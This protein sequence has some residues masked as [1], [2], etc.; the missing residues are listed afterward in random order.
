MPN[1]DPRWRAVL[2]AALTLSLVLAA[3]AFGAAPVGAVTG[4]AEQRQRDPAVRIEVDVIAPRVPAPGGTLTVAGRVVNNSE[5]AL[6]GGAVRLRTTNVPLTSRSQVA[7]LASGQLNRDGR[8]LARARA[9]LGET[10]APGG[11]RAFSIAVPLDT[12]GL[13]RFGVYPLTLEVRGDLG[14]G[15]RSLG[16]VRTF[17]PWSPE[18]K[19]YRELGVSWLWPVL[20][21]PRRTGPDGAFHDDT[22][23]R[24]IAATGRLGR[25][26]AAG[27]SASV[28]WVVDPDLLESVADMADGYLVAEP[29]GLVEGT[30]REAATAWLD[31]LR[32][33]SADNE[34]VA[35]HFADIDVAGLVEAGLDGQVRVAADRGVKVAAQVLGREVLTDVGWLAGGGLEPAALAAQYEVGM[36]AEI[37]DGALAPRPVASFTPTART[38]L[39][40]GD[41]DLAGLVAD[42]VLSDLAGLAGTAGPPRRAQ[43]PGRAGTT[44]TTG[45]E[46]SPALAVQRFL[47]ETAMII[48][49]SPGRARTV[50]V[51]PPRGWSPDPAALTGMLLADAEAPWTAPASL[52]QLR[53]MPPPAPARTS[54]GRAGSRGENGENREDADDLGTTAVGLPAPYLT[55]VDRLRARADHIAS[56]LVDPNP[57]RRVA[58]DIAL[59]LSSAA[60]AGRDE[61][62]E[63]VQGVREALLA[64]EGRVH[65]V[66]GGVTFGGRSGV[67]PITVVNERDEEVNVRVELDAGSEKL[68]ITESEPITVA[69]RSSGQVGFPTQARATG[70]VYVDAQLVTMTGEPYGPRV[71]KR[72]SITQYGTVGLLVT[73]GAALVLFGMATLRVVRRARAGGGRGGGTRVRAV[74]ESGDRGLPQAQSVEHG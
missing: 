22:L 1:R 26:V 18:V 56:L 46:R 47:A 30:G 36:R 66:P 39:P 37:V 61:R 65:I 27:A 72:V 12:L 48:A 51:A 55:A 49:E 20:A 59:R 3:G 6:V 19:E 63:V 24:E 54:T 31:G 62:A 2:V 50:L 25:L 69:A 13:D 8:P 74:G 5:E 40:A 67:L 45:A 43:T 16:R 10:V 17:L 42:P 52:A 23:A 71:R 57:S 53:A 73:V 35:L 15:P 9:E 64:L 38:R 58:R 7:R 32:A 70:I 28:T 14:R 44:G 33:A 29:E 21:V 11:Q 41:A 34:V 60:W 4:G 68:D